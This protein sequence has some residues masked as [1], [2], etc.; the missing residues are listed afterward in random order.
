LPEVSP[1][2]R[3]SFDDTDRIDPHPVLDRPIAPSIF[4]DEDK[5]NLHP[6]GP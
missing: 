2:T 4:D 1:V 3:S 6:T 5:Q